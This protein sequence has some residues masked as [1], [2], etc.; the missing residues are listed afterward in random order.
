MTGLK[1][2]GS[3][4]TPI[5]SQKKKKKERVELP[6]INATNMNVRNKQAALGQLNELEN[7]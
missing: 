2:N 1:S 5:S 3:M 6:D 7:D 4:V